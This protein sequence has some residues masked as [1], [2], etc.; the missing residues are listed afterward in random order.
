L[1][2]CHTFVKRNEFSGDFEMRKRKDVTLA[3]RLEPGLKSA[4]Y[5]AAKKEVGLEAADVIRELIAQYVAG[6]ITLIRMTV[7]LETHHGQ[8]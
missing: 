3:V 4:L 1:D 5:K 6:R 8:Q 2:P 7:Q